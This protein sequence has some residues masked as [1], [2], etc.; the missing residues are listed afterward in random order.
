MLEFI[1]VRMAQ[2]GKYYVPE[3]LTIQCNLFAAARNHTVW[4]DS[5]V[6]KPERCVISVEGRPNMAF[7]IL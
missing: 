3:G 1:T 4:E 7:L 2:V 6:F 5:L